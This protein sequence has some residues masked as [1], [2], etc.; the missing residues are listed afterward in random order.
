M[1][2][3]RHSA[4]RG[5]RATKRGWFGHGRTRAL[6]SLGLVFG[7]GAVGTMAYWTDQGTMTAGDISAGSLDL[8]LNNA[9]TLIGQGGTWDNTAFAASSLIPGESVAFSFPV[10]N[11][12]SAEFR[13]SATATA[14][15]TLATGLRFTTTHGASAASNSGSASNGNRVGTCGANTV[16]TSSVTLSGASSSVIDTPGVTLASGTST[17]V[18]V[19]VALDSSAGN[20]L[21]SATGTAT[22]VFN[23]VQLP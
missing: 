1:T 21:Q 2:K 7:F 9:S 10:R 4:P 3:G 19:I 11:D 6:L 16:G 23:A 12:G 17:T 18:C 14:S 15:G 5:R 8:R 13:F 22:Y 20:A